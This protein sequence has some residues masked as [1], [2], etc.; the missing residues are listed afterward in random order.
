MTISLAPGAW[1]PQTCTLPTT[2]QPIRVAEF[3]R[4]VTEA[5]HGIRRPSPARLELLLSEGT[6]LELMARDLAARESRCCSF[7]TFEFATTAVGS[8]L[9]VGVPDSHAA[10]LDTFAVRAQAAIGGAR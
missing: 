1:V 10:V 6:E 2:E 7:F 9:R 3:D 8:V 5:V 4:F